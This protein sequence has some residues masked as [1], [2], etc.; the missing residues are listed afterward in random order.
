MVK[1]QGDP[2]F[3]SVYQLGRFFGIFILFAIGL[4]FRFGVAQETR[5]ESDWAH[6]L[7]NP[8]IALAVLNQRIQSIESSENKAYREKIDF[9]ATTTVGH[10]YS[11]RYMLSF[12]DLLEQYSEKLFIVQAMKE[13]EIAAFRASLKKA[14]QEEDFRDRFDEF[15][16][17]LRQVRGGIIL[18]LVNSQTLQKGQIENLTMEL[19]KLTNPYEI[20]SEVVKWQGA[21]S[22]VAVSGMFCRNLLYRN[23]L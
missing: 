20:A 4:V 22:N 8:A 21:T 16:V 15:L 18:Q 13:Y 14:T 23:T 10:N 19:S 9:L 12:L 3:Q 1:S 11:Y 17:L 6:N 7:G 5:I 2:S